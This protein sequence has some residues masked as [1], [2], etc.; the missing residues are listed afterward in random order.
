MSRFDQVL[1]EF[2]G[3]CDHD[4]HPRKVSYFL[5]LD[6]NL[7]LLPDIDEHENDADDE[8]RDDGQDAEERDAEVESVFDLL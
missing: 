1:D 4:H 2:D 5:S 6:I 8:K 3:A 7:L